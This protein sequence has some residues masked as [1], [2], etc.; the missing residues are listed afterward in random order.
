MHTIT[1]THTDTMVSDGA[2]ERQKG[3]G[4]CPFSHKTLECEGVATL[5]LPCFP[6]KHIRA[7][8]RTKPLP[9][10]QPSPFL[11]LLSPVDPATFRNFGGDNK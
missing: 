8:G 10:K 7:S 5:G 1:H 9:H 4:V 6:H 2:S 3:V 11:M